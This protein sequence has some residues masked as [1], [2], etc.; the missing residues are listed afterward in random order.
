MAHNTGALCTYHYT[1]INATNIVDRRDILNRIVPQVGDLWVVW[2]A[3]C[4]DATGNTNITDV[5]LMASVDSTMGVRAFLATQPDNTKGAYIQILSPITQANI[6]LHTLWQDH[7]PDIGLPLNVEKAIGTSG[8]GSANVQV[9]AGLTDIRPE[10]A[11]AATTRSLTALNATD[12]SGLGYVGPTAQIG[13]PIK[14]VNASSVKAATPVG[15]SLV[16][17]AND[18]ISGAGKTVRT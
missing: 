8:D 9:N 4:A 1:G 5:W 12:W 13:A 6:V 2:V 10:D 3:N 18:P 16:P 7:N 14:S 15:F 17:G 11:L